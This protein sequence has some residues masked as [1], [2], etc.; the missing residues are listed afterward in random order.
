MKKIILLGLMTSAA[1][2]AAGSPMTFANMDT[3]SDGKVTQ[4]EFQKAQAARMTARAKD[5]RQ[6][7]NAANAGQ[8]TDIDADKNGMVTES[9]FKTFQQKHRQGNMK[10]RKG[11]GKGQGMRKGR[12]KGQG[13][14]M[15]RGQGMMRGGNQS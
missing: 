11:Q 1:I 14:G 10:N 4:E 8:F 13:K 6:M 9:E 15:H 12:G 2:W 7:K 5:G 3:N